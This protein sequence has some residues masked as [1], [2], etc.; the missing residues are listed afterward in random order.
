MPWQTS[1]RRLLPKVLHSSCASTVVLGHWL[2]DYGM[3]HLMS[4]TAFAHW[5]RYQT[6]SNS[7]LAGPMDIVAAGGVWGD[8]WSLRAFAIREFRDIVVIAPAQVQLY[9]SDVHYAT[10]SRRNGIAHSQAP[11][12]IF[13]SRYAAV[14]YDL[15]DAA[16]TSET[17]F[18]MYDGATHYWPAYSVSDVHATLPPSMQSAEHDGLSILK[19]HS[20]DEARNSRQ[21]CISMLN[22]TRATQHYK[23]QHARVMGITPVATAQLS[24]GAASDVVSDAPAVS[25]AVEGLM[26]MGQQPLPLR[27][28]GRTRVPHNKPTV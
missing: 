11:Y 23:V 13:P 18:L 15:P 8:A 7:D 1:L 14:H 16:F 10:P 21:D 5:A 2:H 25:V 19:R 24:P 9:S 17:M 3:L 12:A 4:I 22:D 6:E 26:Q 28:S 20:M 27:R